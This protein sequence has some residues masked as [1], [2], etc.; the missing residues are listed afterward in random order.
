MFNSRTADINW[1]I[2]DRP[3]WEFGHERR[4]PRSL[5]R[6]EGLKSVAER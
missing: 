3:N 5:E 2:G 6:E 4:E 1:N